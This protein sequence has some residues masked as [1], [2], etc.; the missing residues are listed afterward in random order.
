MI[1]TMVL[2]RENYFVQI[3]TNNRKKQFDKIFYDSS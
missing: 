2:L 1:W 3:I